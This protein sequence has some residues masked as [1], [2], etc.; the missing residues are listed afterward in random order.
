MPVNPTKSAPEVPLI[1]L[2]QSTPEEVLDALST[3]GFI[4]LD[5]EGTGIAQAD[6]DRAFEVSALLH[7]VPAPER[8]ESLKDAMGNGYSGMKGSLDERATSTT[9]LKESF[10]WGRYQSTGAESET[11]QILPAAMQKYKQ[12][13][14]NFDDKC[15]EASLRVLD[16]ISQA[17]DVRSS[18]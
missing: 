5:L 17:F 15:F 12:E 6:I 16:V 1:S 11:N 8:A 13:I 18:P 3:I 4:H 14:V 10:V 9:D 7:S 2:V